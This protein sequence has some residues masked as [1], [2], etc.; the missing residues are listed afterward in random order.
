[1]TYRSRCESCETGTFAEFTSFSL[2]PRS[3]KGRAVEDAI[4]IVLIGEGGG[5]LI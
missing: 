5:G 3:G 4:A 2:F 1:M